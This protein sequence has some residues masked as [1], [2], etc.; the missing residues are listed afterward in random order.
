MEMISWTDRERN[1]EIL[2]RVKEERNILYAIK[3][4]KANWIGHLLCR[5]C[6]LKQVT[7]GKIQNEDR[8]DGKTRK[9]T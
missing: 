2:H 6:L 9:K 8:N 4:V 5:Y 1:E 7:E 3:I